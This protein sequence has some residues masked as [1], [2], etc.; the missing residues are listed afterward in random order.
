[1]TA[2]HPFA[3]ITFDEIIALPNREL[4]RVMASGETPD[5]ERLAGY[6]FR[7]FNPPFFAK[8]LGFQK[9]MKGFWVDEAQK[10]AGYNL[11]V[12]NPRGGPTAPWEPTKGGGPDARHGFYDVAPVQGMGRYTDFPN[13]VLLDYGSGRNSGLN[14]ESRIRDFLVRVDPGSDDLFL[15]KA[16]LDLGLFRVFSNFFIL[17]RLREAP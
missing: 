15:G 7:G 13:A 10:L 14:P 16:Y 6:E 17:E 11:F 8:L 2:S 12:K 5:A 9:F 3:G 4:D 1:M